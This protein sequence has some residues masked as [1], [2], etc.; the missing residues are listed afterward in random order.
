MPDQLQFL[1]DFQVGVG[2][3]ITDALLFVDGFTQSESIASYSIGL[4][5]SLNSWQDGSVKVGFSYALM[6][7]ETVAY[8]ADGVAESFFASTSAIALIVAD[9]TL[10]QWQDLI[11][12]FAV[13]YNIDIQEALT[14][15]DLLDLGYGLEL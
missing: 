9:A 1:D 14:L 3:K 13:M 6:V 2:L 10:A 5:D 11:P 12:N 4:A 8:W 15:A 7:S